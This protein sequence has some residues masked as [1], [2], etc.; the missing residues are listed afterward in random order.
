GA[1]QGARRPGSRQPVVHVTQGTQNVDPDDLIRPTLEALAA[2]DV[3]V[4]ATTGLRDRTELPFAVPANARVSDFVPHSEL[5][6]HVDVMV[7]NGGW[8]GTLAALSHGVP[9]VV[10]G[11]DL[12]K[13]EVAA[14][15]AWS[16]AGVNL[17]TGRPNAQRVRAAVERV[18][19]DP[20]FGTSARTI[21]DELAACGGVGRALDLIEQLP[22]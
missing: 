2:M 13:P 15:V 22:A 20:S 9:L 21:A 19:R 3:L 18:L 6:P 4:I 1:A 10:A 11:G 17:K 5:L 14:R 7:T 12:D 8:G 16:G